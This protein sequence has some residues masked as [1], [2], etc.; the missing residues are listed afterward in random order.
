METKVIPS[1]KRY[2]ILSLI[3]H[4]GRI[5]F[6]SLQSDTLEFSLNGTSQKMVWLQGLTCLAT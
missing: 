5:D 6:N 1:D 2:L 3:L 4:A